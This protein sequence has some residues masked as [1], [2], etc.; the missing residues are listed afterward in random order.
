MSYL[1]DSLS[2]LLAIRRGGSEAYDILRGGY[3]LSLALYE[4]GNALWKETALLE[5]LTKNEA[6]RVLAILRS[7]VGKLVQLVEPQSWD[8]VLGLALH[9][10]ITCYDSAYVVAIHEHGSTLVTENRRLRHKLV[11]QAGK[12]RE[13]L[14]EEVKITGLDNVKNMQAVQA[15]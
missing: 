12:V 1:F 13:I 4:A 15:D 7:V 8:N 2:L 11:A 14:G 6:L 5:T 9:L 10:K 3:T